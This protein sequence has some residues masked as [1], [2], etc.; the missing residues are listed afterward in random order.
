MPPLSILMTGTVGE[1]LPV[2]VALV[3][4]VILVVLP[5]VVLLVVAVDEG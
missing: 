2:F 5:V 3:V 4:V 1:I